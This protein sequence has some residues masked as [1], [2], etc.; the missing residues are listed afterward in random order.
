M[1]DGATVIHGTLVFR[2]TT[3]NRSAAGLSRVDRFFMKGQVCTRLR[4]SGSG[5]WPFSAGFLAI[6]GSGRR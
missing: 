2:E 6:G 4:V 3:A 5:S 1:F